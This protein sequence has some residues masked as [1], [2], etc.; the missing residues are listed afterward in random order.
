VSILDNGKE[1]ENIEK[2]NK[3]RIIDGLV[4][5]YDP[6]LGFITIECIAKVD[7]QLLKQRLQQNELT[8][9]QRPHMAI[10]A[11]YKA[12]LMDLDEALDDEFH[13]QYHFFKALVNTDIDYFPKPETVPDISKIDFINPNLN[14]DQ[15]CAVAEAL[16]A[17]IVYVL[18][19]PPGTGKTTVLE[20]IIRQL[21]KQGQRILVCATSHVST[22]NLAERFINSGIDIARLGTME[23]VSNKVKPITLEYRFQEAGILELSSECEKLIE[24]NGNEIPDEIAC[25]LGDLK[26][27]IAE[28]S[29]DI[30]A[31]FLESNIVFTTV[32]GAREFQLVKYLQET[33]NYYDCFIIDE[34]AQSPEISCWLPIFNGRKLIVAGDHMQLSYVSKSQEAKKNSYTKSLLERLMNSLPHWCKR[35]LK[36]QYRMNSILNSW[37]SKQFYG[38]KLQPCE[39]I[40]MRTLSEFAK[41]WVKKQDIPILTL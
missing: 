17:S 27:A 22:D 40:A 35:T 12:I 3:E 39:A 9:L 5:E 33:Q 15:K 30:R 38:G 25:Q 26:A 19:G 41:P 10:F 18:Q 24:Q 31:Q 16:Q 34:C 14:E 4:K 36:I 2:D 29:Q 20:E 6:R 37:P 8:I 11:K 28:K 13:P 7:Q 1:N 21:N 32:N 23:K